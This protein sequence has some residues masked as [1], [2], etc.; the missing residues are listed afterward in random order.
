M[1]LL[2]LI[3]LSNTPQP[4][5]VHAEIVEILDSQKSCLKKVKEIPK[6]EIP[7]NVNMGC[8]A[9]NNSKRT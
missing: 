7:P 1:W 5:V 6:S 3:Q 9:L 4:H 8:V 2:L